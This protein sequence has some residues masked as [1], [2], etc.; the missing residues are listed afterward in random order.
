MFK[1]EK[2]IIDFLEKHYIIFA[3]I[4]ITLFALLAR[5]YM[6]GYASNDFN[7]ALSKWFIY[8]KQSGGLFALKNNIGDYNAPYMTILALLTY[9]PI[10][11]LYSI[12]FVSIFFDFCLAISCSLLVGELIKDD[13]RKKVYMLITYTLVLFIPSVLTNSALWAQCDSIYTTF[14]ILSILFLIK[15]K[16][17]KSFIMLGIAF[18]FKLQAILIL[19]L[20]I[21]LY[22]T[23][24]KFSILNFLIIPLMNVVM[25]LPAIIF[26]MPIQNCF[27][28]YFTQVGEYSGY[29]VLNFPNIY[30][31]LVGHQN[32]YYKV[33]EIF[34][35]VL[36]ALTLIYVIYK[37]VKWNNE[38]IITLGL[39][40]LVVITYFLPGMHER[41]MYIGEVLSIIY[42]LVYRKN[43][44]IIIFMHLSV[45]ITYSVVLLYDFNYMDIASMIYFVLIIYF[46]KDT[47]KLLSV[48]KK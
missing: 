6:I 38:K 18:G 42:F 7:V 12:K 29:L 47:V 28:A 20:Y 22:V 14:V 27:Q 9:L 2:R 10:K 8:L 32:I 45:F 26:G 24:K 15:E 31:L 1:F 39:W 40:L 33:G 25:C 13:K 34:V 21:I 5:R 3:F 36:C 44:P 46:T 16:Y 35:I 37:K 19:P 23:T 43:L 30:N 17:T 41:Y 48:N 4:A 11:S